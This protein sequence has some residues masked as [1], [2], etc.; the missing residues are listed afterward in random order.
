MILVI[1]SRDLKLVL[2]LDMKRRFSNT[3]RCMLQSEFDVDVDKDV[4]VTGMRE[5]LDVDTGE[6]V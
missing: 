4:P 2:D 3:V 6:I 5:M 1:R